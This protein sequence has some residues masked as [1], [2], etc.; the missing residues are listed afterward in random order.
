MK[1]LLKTI[2]PLTVIALLLALTLTACGKSE[3]AVTEN[4]GKQMTITAEK[5]GKDAFFM[6]DSLEVGDGEQ[7]MISS[8][9]TKGSI[10]VEII[11]ESEEQSIDEL[12]ELFGEAVLTLVA[13]SGTEGITGTVPEGSYAL[14]ATCLERA[15]GT[16]RIE[17]KPAA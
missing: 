2:I 8:S 5:A 4:T 16:V 11:R 12:P 10:R 7:I 3:F 15:S 17:V 9:L 1:R 13:D 6:V 14:C